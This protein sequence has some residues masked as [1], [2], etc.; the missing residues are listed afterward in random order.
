L[1]V[2][3]LVVVVTVVK[4]LNANAVITAVAKWFIVVAYLLPIFKKEI[5]II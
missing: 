2:V 4:L 5:T 1:F 3:Y